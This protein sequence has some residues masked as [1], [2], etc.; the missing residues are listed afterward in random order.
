[1]LT[2]SDASLSRSQWISQMDFRNV[3]FIKSLGFDYFGKI[4]NLLYIIRLH[5]TLIS[6]SN[7]IQR[8]ICRNSQ[9]Q[10]VCQY[11]SS[12]PIQQVT[13]YFLLIRMISKWS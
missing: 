11:L 2:F 6:F 3:T 5:N 4:V 10:D 8:H 1:M 13:I 12:M 9:G 7:V